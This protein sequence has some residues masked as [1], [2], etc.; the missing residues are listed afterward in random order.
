MRIKLVFAR[1]CGTFKCG[2][3]S[4]FLHNCVSKPTSFRHDQQVFLGWVS[5]KTEQLL[6][7]YI[8]ILLYLTIKFNNSE[9][10]VSFSSGLDSAI[11]ITTATKVSSS[12]IFLL[13]TI[14]ML[15]LS[16]K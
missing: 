8:L 1:V 10:I 6:N 9:I 13:S 4:C 14:S 16:K 12:I 3:H 15:F 2:H 11:N 5:A 7:N